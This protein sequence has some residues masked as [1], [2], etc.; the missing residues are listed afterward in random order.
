MTKISFS[1]NF[2]FFSLKL[3]NV[4]YKEKLEV[5]YRLQISFLILSP[6]YLTFTYDFRANTS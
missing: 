6:N 3:K 2:C 4:T 1:L 5:R